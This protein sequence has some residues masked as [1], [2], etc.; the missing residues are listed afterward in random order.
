MSYSAVQYADGSVSVSPLPVAGILGLHIG[1]D[2]V[3]ILLV[4]TPCGLVH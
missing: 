4:M 3:V 2:R 1:E